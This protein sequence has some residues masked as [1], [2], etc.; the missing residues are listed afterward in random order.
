MIDGEWLYKAEGK[1]E[2]KGPT[3][4]SIPCKSHRRSRLASSIT[5]ANFIDLGLE[6][7]S[8]LVSEGLFLPRLGTP[9]GLSTYRA[10]LTSTI[11]DALRQH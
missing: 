4:L 8:S 9:L 1:Q 3:Y 10:G 2:T 7:W 6:L 5:F 11:A